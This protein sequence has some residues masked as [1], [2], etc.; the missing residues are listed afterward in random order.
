MNTEREITIKYLGTILQKK[1]REI[2]GM[3]AA[4]NRERAYR[5]EVH[6]VRMGLMGMTALEASAV[7]EPEP[8]AVVEE[9]V[10][11]S[12]RDKPKRRGR[13][14]TPDPH[15]QKIISAMEEFMSKED[16]E[17]HRNE[18]MAMLEN[19]EGVFMDAASP[20]N[21]LGGYLS[22]YPQFVNTRP[23]KGWW[24]LR[25]VAERIKN[26]SKKEDKPPPEILQLNAYPQETEQGRNNA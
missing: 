3:Q 9:E 2:E 22:S 19:T 7:S 26:E 6:S 10:K 14:R 15:T 23:N 18:I 24:A 1:D 21:T 12:S 5:Q 8:T 16:G 4:L 13:G 25:E 11:A 20:M 17:V